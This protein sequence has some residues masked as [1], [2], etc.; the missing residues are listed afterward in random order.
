MIGGAMNDDE[1]L[2]EFEQK[3][4]E[5]QKRMESTITVHK[6]PDEMLRHGEELGGILYKYDLPVVNS[7]I[8]FKSQ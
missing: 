5:H 1:F 2:P 6:K 7:P 3:E 8:V 4:M